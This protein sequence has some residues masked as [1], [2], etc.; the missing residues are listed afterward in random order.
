MAE[1]APW[2]SHDLYVIYTKGEVRLLHDFSVGQPPERHQLPMTT[3][4]LNATPPEEASEAG[5]D[6]G[7]AAADPAGGARG[8]AA[9]DDQRP[10]NPTLVSDAAL[11][12]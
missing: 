1:W 11:P 6:A 2:R 4:A 8:A 5:A 10:R 3:E 7:D 12:S 9:E